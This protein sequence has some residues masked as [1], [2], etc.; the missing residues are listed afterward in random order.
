MEDEARCDVA[1][2]KTL[3]CCEGSSYYI[4]A[5]LG[6][7]GKAEGDESTGYTRTFTVFFLW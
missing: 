4:C 6:L 3:F 7:L 1:R 5:V 2:H